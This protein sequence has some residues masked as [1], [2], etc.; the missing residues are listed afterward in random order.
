MLTFQQPGL[1]PFGSGPS[2]AN[3]F[4]STSVDL[5]GLA[6]EGPGNTTKWQSFTGFQCWPWI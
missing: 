6:S 4:G 5:K 3:Q 2:E 1:E